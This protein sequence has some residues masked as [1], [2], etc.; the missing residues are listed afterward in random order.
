[1][2]FERFE[3]SDLSQYSYAVGCHGAKKVAIVDPRRDI[4]VYLNLAQE[5]DLQIAYVL[6]THIH[7][8]FA[9]GARELAE[10]AGAELAISAYDS[11][12]VFEVRFAHTELRDGDEISIGG[13]QIKAVHTPG[14]TPEHL[15]YLVFDTNR[16][17]E[18]PEL[19]LSGDFLFVG[20]IGRPDLLGEEAK[21]G[22]ASQLYDS[23]HQALPALPD[24]LEVHPG[25]GSGSM[26]GAGMSGRPMST[27]GYERITNPY[28]QP[29]SRETFIDQILAASPPFPEYYKRMKRLNSDGPPSLSQAPQPQPIDAGRVAELLAEGQVIVDLRDQAAYAAGH[30]PGAYYVGQSAAMWGSWTLP[31]DRPILLLARDEGHAAAAWYRGLARVGIDDVRGYLEGGM[32][33]WQ[34]H[35]L[36]V[37]ATAQVTPQQLAERLAGGSRTPVLDVRGNPAWATGHIAGATHVIGGHVQDRL[38]EVPAPGDEAL[39]VVCN[40][41]FQSTVIAS[42]LERAGRGDVVNVT[43]GM[44][45]WRAA[46]LPLDPRH[47]ETL[48]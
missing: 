39:A 13:V 25:H 44:T 48:A 36:E 3:D 5:H 2:L 10:V 4:D 6:E 43:G 28:L 40:T 19:L 14:H 46:D 33:A 8:D 35:G 38:E 45:A 42:V 26:C 12:A 23:I 7:A 24:G 27:L 9:S 16:S 30:I 1:M 31:Y 20:S 47:A 41:G 21:R 34:E 32:D 17:A 15:S 22:L 37:V 11:G 18:V 29:M